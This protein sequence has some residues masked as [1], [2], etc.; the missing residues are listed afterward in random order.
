MPQM[1]IKVSCREYLFVLNQTKLDEIL[2][3]YYSFVSMCTSHDVTNCL[4]SLASC[5]LPTIVP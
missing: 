3:V 5:S 1:K 2:S 4:N